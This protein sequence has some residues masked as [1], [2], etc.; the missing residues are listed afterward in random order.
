MLA[1]A[2][3]CEELGFY[4]GMSHKH[5]GYDFTKKSTRVETHRYSELLTID[6]YHCVR[7]SP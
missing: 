4:T 1:R 6:S 3:V 2:H 7:Q 5:I